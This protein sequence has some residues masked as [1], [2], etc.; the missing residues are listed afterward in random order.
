VIDYSECEPKIRK[1]IDT[2]VGFGRE[3]ITG[4]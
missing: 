1:L 3:K 2:H 4:W